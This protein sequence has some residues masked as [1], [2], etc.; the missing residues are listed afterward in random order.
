MKRERNADTSQTQRE[1]KVTDDVQ[2]AL[3]RTRTKFANFLPAASFL[4]C[5]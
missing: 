5:L 1:L 2:S 3:F 4:F